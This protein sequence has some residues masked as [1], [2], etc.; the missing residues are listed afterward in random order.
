[1]C[2]QL[3]GEQLNNDLFSQGSRDS[4]RSTVCVA[5]EAMQAMAVGASTVNTASN[6]CVEIEIFIIYNIITNCCMRL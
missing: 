2:F 5:V 3:V 4:S 6:S 1:M